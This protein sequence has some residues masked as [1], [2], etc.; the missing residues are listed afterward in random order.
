[1]GK[2]IKYGTILLIA[3][4]LLY[5]SVYIKKLSAVRAATPG[6]FDAAAFSKKL[7]TGQLPGRIQTAVPLDTLLQALQANANTAFDKYTNALAIGNIRY[8]LVQASGRVVAIKDDEVIVQAG[9]VP[10]T[11]HLATEFI[12][13]NAIRDASGLVNVKDFVNTTDLNNISDS[14]NKQVR[15]LVLPP[16]KSSVG[17]KDSVWFAGALELNK[18]HVHVQEPEVIPVQVKII[19]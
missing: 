12:Y 18:E 2:L 13:G 5:N 10:V 1:M 14:L 17:V 7:F 15:E 3:G 9:A 6:A 16:F 19:R 4:F 11:V 8:S